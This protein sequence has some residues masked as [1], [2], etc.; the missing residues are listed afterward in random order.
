[1][2]NILVMIKRRTKKFKWFN[3][4]LVALFL[5]IMIM[6]SLQPVSTGQHHSKDTIHI[7]FLHGMPETPNVLMPLQE[8]ISELFLDNDLILDYRYPHLPD[9][10]S[11]DT[12]AANVAREIDI[13]DPTGPIV[14]VGLSMGG[15]VAIHLTSNEEFGVQDRIDSVITINSPLK[16]FDQYFNAFFGYH[17][18]LWLLPFMG[19]TVLGYDTSDG[20]IDVITLD[21]TSEANRIADEKNLLCFISSETATNDPDG[22]GGM[23][24]RDLDDGTI[25]L[26]AQYVDNATVMYYGEKAHEAVFRDEEST[27]II[28]HTIIDF[29]RGLPVMHSVQIKNGQVTFDRFGLT[30]A[31]TFEK[32]LAHCAILNEKRSHFE[33]QINP[34]SSWFHLSMVKAEWNTADSFNGS[35]NLMVSG[36]RAFSQISIDWMIFEQHPVVRSPYI[37]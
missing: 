16:S 13:W 37:P 22:F 1:M 29:L 19:K 8:R 7:L 34:D 11:V 14:I 12:W 36:L 10:E 5:C 32:T 26:K 35:I 33:I 23:F 28:A 30:N 21:S 9:T 4:Q 24:P 15:K 2:I 20:F 31:D 6:L 3:G 18:P 17:Y 25:P 27:E